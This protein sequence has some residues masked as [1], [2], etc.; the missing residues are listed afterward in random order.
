MPPRVVTPVIPWVSPTIPFPFGC[1]HLE[2]EEEEVPLGWG[3]VRGGRGHPLRWHP[4][5]HPG[6]EHLWVWAWSGPQAEEE[7]HASHAEGAWQGEHS[8]AQ[9]GFGPL[10]VQP[11]PPPPIRFFRPGAA[12]IMACMQCSTPHLEQILRSPLVV[13]IQCIVISTSFYHLWVIYKI[14]YQLCFL[15]QTTSWSAHLVTSLIN[16]FCSKFCFIKHKLFCFVN[17]AYVC[18]KKVKLHNNV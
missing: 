12:L 16:K 13:T 7:G 18:L 8:I 6:Q 10:G 9:F 4:V 2:G 5:H 15:S 1:R 3:G 11:P 17:F 14:V